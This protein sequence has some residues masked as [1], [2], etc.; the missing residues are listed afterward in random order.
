MC[1]LVLIALLQRDLLLPDHAEHHPVQGPPT[2]HRSSSLPPPSPGRRDDC[3]QSRA[4]LPELRVNISLTTTLLW[5]CQGMGV[6][7]VYQGGFMLSVGVGDV[8]PVL[9]LLL[10]GLL[11][12]QSGPGIPPGSDIELVIRAELGRVGALS[13]L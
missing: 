2:S 5:V 3:L 7:F 8:A 6:S 11:P 1:R 10:Y 12:A 13:G 4:V 9:M